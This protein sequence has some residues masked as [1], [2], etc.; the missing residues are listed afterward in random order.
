MRLPALLL[1]SAL[2]AVMLGCAQ[3]PVRPNPT[4]TPTPA[5]AGK[6][7][8]YQVFTRLYGNQ[9]TRNKPWGTIAENGVGKFVDFN[10][11]ALASIRQFGT[12]HLWFTG[13]PRHASIGDYG[14]YGIPADDPDV[15]KGRAGSPYAI[16]D[17]YD[18]DPDLAT[19][20]ARRIEEFKALIARRTSVATAARGSA[21]RR[22][23]RVR[24]R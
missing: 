12:T 20:P 14:K 5:I 22:R 4:P 9:E 3:Q 15:V 18:V 1:T 21:R 8:I 6:P 7:V 2:V 13:V 17:Y 10:D 16:T 19:D 24:L 11:A 23:R